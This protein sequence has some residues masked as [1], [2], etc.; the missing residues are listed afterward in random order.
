MKNRI[1]ETAQILICEKGVKGL[2]M[3]FLA[4]DLGISKKTIYTYFK[5]KDELIFSIVENHIKKN[6]L[7]CNE[8]KTKAKN[9]IHALFL[10]IDSMH[11]LFEH[12]TPN[13]ILEIQKHY[14]TAFLKII[15]HKN[16]F[17][18]KMI[19]TDFKRGVKEGLFRND[20]DL[21]IIAKFR[22]ETVFLPFNQHVYPSNKY[23]FQKIHSTLLEFFMY[24]LATP[25]GQK[26]IRQY[27]LKNK[28]TSK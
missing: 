15:E 13:V 26:F 6:E 10:M 22:L 16:S 1:I 20:I 17:L 7:I 3:D 11:S 8:V 23:S 4:L 21:D 25:L 27:K 19:L 9:I 28:K 14:P 2:T 24:G 5:N 12:I 18:Y